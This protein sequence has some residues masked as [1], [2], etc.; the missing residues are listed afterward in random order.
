MILI[1]TD[2]YDLRSHEC[3]DVIVTD[4]NK[5]YWMRI[6]LIDSLYKEPLLQWPSAQGILVNGM[7]LCIDSRYCQRIN[8]YLRVHECTYPPWFVGI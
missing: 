5:L 3:H 2:K 7:G 4:D 1:Q 8:A 6:E